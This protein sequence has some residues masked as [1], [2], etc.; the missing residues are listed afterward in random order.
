[1]Q[2]IKTILL[3]GAVI[4]FILVI[5]G[6]LVGLI[7]KK[8]IPQ[9]IKNALVTGMGLCVL[10]IGIDGMLNNDTNILIIIISMALGA[11]IGELL[12]IDEFINKI[13]LKLEKIINRKNGNTKIA[14]GFVAA[15]LL[16]CVG[17]M[18]IVG[19]IES[20]INGNNSTL[21]SKAVIDCISAIP[22][23]STFGLGV[24]LSCL[25]VLIIEGGLTLLAVAVSP[26]LTQQ[27]ILHMSVTGSILIAALALNMLGITKIKVMNFVPAIFLP[28]IIC[29]II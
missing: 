10:L 19:S 18:T 27:I 17:A 23:A 1:M 28:I 22:L 29:Y 13:S 3:S 26:I 6:A 4:N 8:G 9:K 24:L 2:T 5:I 11:I 16:F 14:E 12:N 7:F 20:G 15:T 21:Y 25:P